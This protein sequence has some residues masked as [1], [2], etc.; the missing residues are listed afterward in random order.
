MTRKT[1]SQSPEKIIVDDATVFR[2]GLPAYF[3]CT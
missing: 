3:F 1:S 2:L